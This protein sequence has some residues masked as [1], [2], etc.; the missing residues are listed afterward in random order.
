MQIQRHRPILYFEN[1]LGEA[2]SELLSYAMEKLGYDLFWHPAQIFDEE[3][4]FGN[5]VNHRTSRDI[6]S[7]MVFCTVRAKGRDT[8]S[9]AHNQQGRLLGGIVSSS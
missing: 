1:D 7:L 9:S 6:V 3:N 5:P 8:E 4:F 2:S